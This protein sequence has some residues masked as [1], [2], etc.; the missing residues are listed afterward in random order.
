MTAEGVVADDEGG[1]G[2]WTAVGGRG[3]GVQ[4]GVGCGERV[5]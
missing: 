3:E 1:V 2:E 5:L 4:L